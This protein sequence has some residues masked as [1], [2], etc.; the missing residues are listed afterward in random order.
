LPPEV[1]RCIVCEA[2]SAP[3]KYAGTSFSECIACGYARLAD[4][5]GRDDYW[6]DATLTHPED[7]YWREAK[8]A[9]FDSALALVGSLGSGRR[10][11]DIGGGVGFF[12]E[13][14]C[15]R[16]WDAVSLDASEKATAVAAG[17]LG[18]KRA[19]SDLGL[20]DGA[21]FDVATLWCVV[22]HTYSPGE[23]VETARRALRPGG[24]IWITTPNFAYQKR[25]AAARSI[26]G[27]PLDFV[28]DDHVGHFTA[29][30]I[31]KLLEGEGFHDVRFHFRGIT[32]TCIVA[33]SD[34]RALIE[35]KRLWNR[36]AFRMVRSGFGNLMSELQVTAKRR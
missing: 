14:A 13:R 8:Q 7:P 33:G 5:A 35:A 17:R 9:Y 20:E 3:R 29:S 10:L 4:S 23:V 6:A 24:H 31:K 21:A 32:E 34:G 12:A 1:D 22:A 27:R 26:I 11:L 25:Y 2:E 16:G 19:C 36:I 28:R 30:A 18:S 15:E